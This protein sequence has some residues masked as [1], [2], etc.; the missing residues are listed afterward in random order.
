M[1]LQVRVSTVV[2]SLVL[3]IDLDMRRRRKRPGEQPALPWRWMSTAEKCRLSVS[4]ATRLLLPKG[5]Q[6]NYGKSTL[7]ILAIP[8]EQ[9]IEDQPRFDVQDPALAGWKRFD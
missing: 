3:T 9:G 8:G 6:R 7:Q 1:K 4:G 2:N 5:C